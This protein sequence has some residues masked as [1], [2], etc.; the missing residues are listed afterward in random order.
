MGCLLVACSS[1]LIV[2]L[3]AFAVAGLIAFWNLDH[4]HHPL[5]LSPT[6]PI[7]LDFAVHLVLAILSAAPPTMLPGGL[8][9][10]LEPRLRTA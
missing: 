4:H 2:N 1:N 5:L 6:C 3:I 8:A 9:G 10:Q 7:F